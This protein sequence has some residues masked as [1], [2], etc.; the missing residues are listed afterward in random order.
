MRILTKVIF[1]IPLMGGE[2]NFLILSILIDLCTIR[3]GII[4]N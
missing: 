4:E 1:K 2:E 3:P